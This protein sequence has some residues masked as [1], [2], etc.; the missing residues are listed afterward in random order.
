MAFAAPTRVLASRLPT[1]PTYLVGTSRMVSAPI[2][3]AL[4]NPL[5]RLCRR[6]CLDHR[7]VLSARV[8]VLFVGFRNRPFARLIPAT[9]YLGLANVIAALVL[10]GV[11]LRIGAGTLALVPRTFIGVW[12]GTLL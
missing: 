10:W 2:S 4:A 6:T 8:F 1:G 5:A 11:T 7:S 12:H 3:T 9:P